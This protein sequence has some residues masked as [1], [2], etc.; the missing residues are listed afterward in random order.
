MSKVGGGGSDVKKNKI[1]VFQCSINR[2]LHLYNSSL[3]Y[4][5]VKLVAFRSSENVQDA[6]GDLSSIAIIRYL[7]IHVVTTS[8]TSQKY[9]NIE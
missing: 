4:L 6:L 8:K 2:Y 7:E 1:T 9:K 3:R 5:P